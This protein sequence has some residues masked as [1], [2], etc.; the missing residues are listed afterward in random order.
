MKKTLSALA[1]SAMLVGSLTACG[2]KTEDNNGATA[3]PE[4]T[5]AAVNASAEYKDGTFEGT[6]NG[7]NG[8]IKV[9]VTVA[10][11][12]ITDIVVK[13]HAETAGIYEGAEA[14]VIPAIIESQS[15][16]V[17]AVASAT[18]SSKGIMEAVANALTEASK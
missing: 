15:T 8:E 11:G 6:G 4:A 3:T 7:N 9:E 13:E 17:D 12:K 16:E 10:E 18:N 5:E 2:E 1:L 14:A